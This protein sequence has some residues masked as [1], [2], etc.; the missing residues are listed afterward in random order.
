MRYIQVS[1]DVE[2]KG[3]Q[4]ILWKCLKTLKTLFAW[5]YILTIFSE[6]YHGLQKDP[7]NK[8]D[9]TT[10]NQPTVGWSDVHWG[11]GY[12]SWIASWVVWVLQF[13]TACVF[14]LRGYP[15]SRCPSN[16]VNSEVIVFVDFQGLHCLVQRWY[17]DTPESCISSC[18]LVEGKN[19]ALVDMVCL[20]Y[21]SELVG[22]I[23]WTKCMVW[24]CISDWKWD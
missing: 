10:F 23:S 7:K 13:G 15:Y 8:R 18:F 9:C 12:G 14:W 16:H 3:L 4:H 19:P 20:L 17:F 6:C 5:Q 21:M 24:T 1:Y 11:Y 22:R 2:L